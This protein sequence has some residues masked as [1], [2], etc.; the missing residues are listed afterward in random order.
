MAEIFFISDPH[1][2]HANI[3]TFVGVDGKPIRPHFSNV[4]EM[5]E[6][7]IERWNAVVRPQDKVW[8]LGDVFFGDFDEYKKIHSRLN[9]HQRLLL[10]NHDK[11]E[12]LWTTRMFKKIGV[13]RRFDEYGFVCSHIPMNRHSCFNHRQNDYLVNVHGHVHEQDVPDAGYVNISCEKTNYAPI[14]LEDLKKL[15]D[16]EKIRLTD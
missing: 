5:N 10:G 14:H 12:R 1:W 13:I 15:V 7:M 11:D 2:N 16:Y 4:E 9:G 3:L 6:V 8:N